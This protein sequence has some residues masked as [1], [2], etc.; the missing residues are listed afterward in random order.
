[1]TEFSLI[2][3]KPW[4]AGQMSR[5]LRREHAG[6]IMA[7]GRPIHSELRHALDDS[8]DAQAWFVNGHLAGLGGVSA[9]LA[10][11]LGRVWLALSD[12]AMHYPIAIVKTLTNKIESLL[13]VHDELATTSLIGDAPS[14]RLLKF[15]GFKELGQADGFIL[16]SLGRET[17]HFLVS[18]APRSRH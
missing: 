7:M 13:E 10:S 3:A 11:S 12:D 18:S 6:I 14:Q 8:Y 15:V 4:H 1:M 16:H 5:I 2:D 9:T 17:W